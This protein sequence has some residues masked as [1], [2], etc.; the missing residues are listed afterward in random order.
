MYG[1]GFILHS[2]PFT[3][4]LGSF[5]LLWHCESFYKHVLHILNLKD[6]RTIIFFSQ[7][8][9]FIYYLFQSYNPIIALI[10]LLIYILFNIITI[11]TNE[12]I[13]ALSAK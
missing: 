6:T 13:F 8:L 5:V 12:F 2:N 10:D 1:R 4:I 7:N 11:F 3:F 9:F